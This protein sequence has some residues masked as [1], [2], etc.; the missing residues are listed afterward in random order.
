MRAVGGADRWGRLF[1][2]F[3]HS[4]GS[5]ALRLLPTLSLSTLGIPM[6]RGSLKQAHLQSALL[7][8]SSRVCSLL[9]G[10]GFTSAL[11]VKEPRRCVTM[12]A[13][14][15]DFLNSVNIYKSVWDCTK[16]KVHCMVQEPGLVV[17]YSSRS[18]AQAVGLRW[19]C[20]GSPKPGDLWHICWNLVVLKCNCDK[21]LWEKVMKCGEA[22]LLLQQTALPVS[23]AALYLGPGSW[24]G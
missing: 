18:R 2:V 23:T 21:S 10:L 24:K 5:R 15:G 11:W 19:A 22:G 8:C 6:D 7:S 14:Y 1:A 13:I 16:Y 12:D 3:L 17:T 20:E 9:L 4:L